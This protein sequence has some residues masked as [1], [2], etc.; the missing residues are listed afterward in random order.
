MRSKIETQSEEAEKAVRDIRR[1]TRAR[2]SAKITG[3]AGNALNCDQFE[4]DRMFLR[5]TTANPSK[6]PANSRGSSCEEPQLCDRSLTNLDAELQQLAVDARR[7]PQWIGAVHLP[8]QITN[9]ATY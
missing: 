7:I 5:S 2:S 9:F 4:G 1:A 8:D 6:P 3:L